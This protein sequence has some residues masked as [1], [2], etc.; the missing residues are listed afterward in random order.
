M[1]VLKEKEHVDSHGF[2]LTDAFPLISMQLL[3]PSLFREIPVQ[4]RGANNPVLM[5]L[6]GEQTP[7][8][9]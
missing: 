9:C 1:L 6:V 5:L 2:A 3:F 7:G 4:F 8:N